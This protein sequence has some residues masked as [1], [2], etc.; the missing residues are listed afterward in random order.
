MRCLS[1]EFTS[2]AAKLGECQLNR[3]GLGLQDFYDH[4]SGTKMCVSACQ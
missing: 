4:L 2:A 1:T 3:V